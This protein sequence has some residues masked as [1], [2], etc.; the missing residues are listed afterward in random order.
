LTGISTRL[1]L[2]S[3][4]SE[5]PEIAAETGTGTGTLFTELPL[6]AAGFLNRKLFGLGDWLPGVLCDRPD[7]TGLPG[8]EVDSTCPVSSVANF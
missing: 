1:S 6:I 8:A 5:R 4:A 2:P 3:E 7:R